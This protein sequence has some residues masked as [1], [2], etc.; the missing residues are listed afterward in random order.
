VDR[1]I[2]VALTK[3]VEDHSHHPFNKNMLFLLLIIV[4]APHSSSMS[5]QSTSYSAKY[6]HYPR[7]YK[8]PKCVSHSFVDK[9]DGDI[10]KLEWSSEPWTEE[11][12][13]IRGPA[14]SPPE[15]RPPLSCRTRVKM[16]W[17]E[18]YLYIAALL[19]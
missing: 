2:C 4:S 5:S 1:L 18:K 17:D 14:D 9:I 6:N 3:E 10:S 13:D 7:S 15:S 11:F 16:M 19:E 8:A 12:D